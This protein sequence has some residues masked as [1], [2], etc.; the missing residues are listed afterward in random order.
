MWWFLK[1][2]LM[3]HGSN[4]QRSNAQN[5]VQSGHRRSNLA[6]YLIKLGLIKDIGFQQVSLNISIIKL[7]LNI[8]VWLTNTPVSVS[9][10]NSNIDSP[11]VH[12]VELGWECIMLMCDCDKRWPKG[13]PPNHSNWAVLSSG[14]CTQL[15]RLHKR[16]TWLLWAL[17]VQLSYRQVRHHYPYNYSL[18][19]FL[20]GI[21]PALRGLGTGIGKWIEYSVRISW[22]LL[23]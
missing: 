10:R 7:A 21:V 12:S 23:V 20:N 17:E 5:V 22:V 11:V 19:L 1:M 8:P 3:P 9:F 14:S 16:T 2:T 4:R 13:A 6:I 18:S 15:E